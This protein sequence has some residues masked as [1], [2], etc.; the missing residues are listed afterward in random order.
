[1]LVKFGF[2]YRTT[3]FKTASISPINLPLLNRQRD[4]WESVFIVKALLLC[5]VDVDVVDNLHED[6]IMVPGWECL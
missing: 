4:W 5:T 1:M 2:S 6:M 3:G